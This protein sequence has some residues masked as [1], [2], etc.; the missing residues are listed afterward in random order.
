[1]GT[2]TSVCVAAGGVHQTVVAG[3]KTCTVTANGNNVNDVPNI[4]HAV[5]RCGDGGTIIFPEDQNYWIATK[6]NP[7]FNDVQIQWHGQW[8]V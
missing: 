5:Q 1:L 8:T 4:L 7:V 3:R 2:V 6:L